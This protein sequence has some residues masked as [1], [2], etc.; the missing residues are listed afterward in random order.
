MAPESRIDHLLLKLLHNQ[1]SDAEK[2]ELFRL[3][4]EV[5]DEEE[6]S[7]LL[8]RAWNGYEQPSHVLEEAP[9]RAILM[10]IFADH[11]N[12]SSTSLRPVYKRWYW[13]AAAVLVAIVAVKVT[14][15]AGKNKPGNGTMM[16]ANTADINA[17]TVSKAC[18]TLANGKVIYLD[19]ATRGTLTEEE[20][21]N[22]SRKSGESVVYAADRDMKS[23]V[24]NTLSNP[25]GS[26]VVN[27]VLSDGTKVWLNSESSLR[28]PISLVGKDRL[29]TVTGEAYFEVATNAA[30]PFKV[31]ANNIVVDVLGT[32]FNIN[33]YPE[34]TS[35]VTT[36]LAGKVKLTGKDKSVL[37]HPGQ[38]AKFF[39][40]LPKPFTIA[41][42]VDIDQIMAWKNGSFQFDNAEL[43]VIMRQLGRWYDVNIVYEKPPSN[44][45][46]GGNIRMDASLQDALKMLEANGV[47]CHISGKNVIVKP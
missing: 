45:K 2:E 9:S 28:F 16:A 6:L 38:Q 26:K 35:I 27:L 24:Y 30:Q 25:R 4:G 29:V 47:N 3:T 21:V 33:A 39:P 5:H 15:F 44:E 18:I 12:V 36:L 31:S 22:V 13:A 40:A 14:F 32:H 46:F 19:K 1:C 11:N 8:E 37:L 43:P 41:D 20:G 7:A 34:E 17:P 23:L 42:D 10:A